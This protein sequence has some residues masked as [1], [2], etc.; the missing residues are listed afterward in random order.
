MRPVRGCGAFMSV[1]DSIDS[2]NGTKD[3]MGRRHIGRER[4]CFAV[5][6]GKHASS[7]EQ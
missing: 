1:Y 5:D 2:T 7:H 3:T 4:F 6:R